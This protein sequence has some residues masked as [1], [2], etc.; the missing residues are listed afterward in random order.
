MGK[1]IQ[2]RHIRVVEDQWGDRDR[3][4]AKGG[5]VRV[6]IDAFDTAL[7]VEPIV[8]AAARIGAGLQ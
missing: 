7:F 8:A 4:F 3:A 2:R 5:Y 1:M 6:R